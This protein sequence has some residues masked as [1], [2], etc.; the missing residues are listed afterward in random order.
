[1]YW[2]LSSALAGPACGHFWQIWPSQALAKVLTGLLD[3]ADFSIA[4]E[5]TVCLQLKV[6]KLVLACHHLSDLTVTH[7]HPQL[8]ELITRAVELTR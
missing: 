6:M 8:I 3:L 1:M 5:H 2:S 7:S 4:A